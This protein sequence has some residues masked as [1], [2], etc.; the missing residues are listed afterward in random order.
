MAKEIFNIHHITPEYN[1]IKSIVEQLEKGAV[2]LYP[3]D[4]GFA[5]GCRISDKNA[6][7]RIR[8]IRGLKPDS[9]MTFICQGLTNISEFAKVNNEAYKTIKSLIPGP[10][11]FILP[12]SKEVPKFA[13]HPK[14]NT[15]GIR[16]PD[17][18][19]TQH[20]TAELG[21]PLIS[22]SAVESGSDATVDEILESL[23]NQVDIVITHE[24]YDFEAESTIIDMS[25]DEFEIIREGAGIELLEEMM[26]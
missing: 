14:R 10:Y 6:I 8:R 26:V 22:I 1:K 4:S 25:S 24:E 13:Q 18:V 11:T 15:S 17:S 23:K 3:T 16:V 2:I 12:A 19:F 9:N 21:T 5:L 20:L 7:E